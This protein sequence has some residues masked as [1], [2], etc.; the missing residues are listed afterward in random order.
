ML[1]PAEMNCPHLVC[2]RFLM[3]PQH[4]IQPPPQ[5][6]QPTLQLVIVAV[7]VVPVFIVVAAPPRVTSSGAPSTSTPPTRSSSSSSSSSGSSSSGGGGGDRDVRSV[8]EDLHQLKQAVE[9]VC[10][11]RRVLA[12]SYVFKFYQFEDP[13]LERELLLFESY[14]GKLERMTEDLQTRLTELSFSFTTSQ[15]DSNGR[16]AAAGAG[17]GSAGSS[18]APCEDFKSWRQNVM[19]LMGA[20]RTF[21]KHV[22]SFAE[23]AEMYSGGAEWESKSKGADASDDRQPKPAWAWQDDSNTWNPFSDENIRQVEEAHTREEPSVT[24]TA[25]GRRYRIDLVKM[26]Q[27]NLETHGKRVVRR[28]LES[29]G[30]AWTCNHCTYH[31]SGQGGPGQQGGGAAQG[32]AAAAVERCAACDRVRESH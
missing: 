4:L 22:V 15:S 19:H 13:S 26:L 31:N 6:V 9:Q 23:N 12:W 8:E 20:V 3:L 24:I 32:G 14:Q 27:E 11:S 2:A 28:R 17:A 7:F 30:G 21:T 16:A 5:P 10:L 18:N 25:G 29:N 1:A